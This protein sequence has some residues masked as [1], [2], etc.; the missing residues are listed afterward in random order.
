MS[1]RDTR[2]YVVGLTGGVGSGKSTAAAML[3]AKGVFVI[4]VD[5]I[6]RALSSKG[7]AAVSKIADAFPDVMHNGEIDRT[8]LRERVFANLADRKLLE[9]ILHPMIREQTALELASNAAIDAPYSLLVVPLLFESN[10]YASLIECAVVVDVSVE[11]QVHRVVT[12][13]GVDPAVARNIVAAQ[14][15]REARLSRAQFV[16]NNE[17]DKTTLQ[18]QMDQLH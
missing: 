8:K 7:G 13:R 6:S 1:A 18:R 12:T 2:S 5:D 3:L 17:G 10:A 16:L 11:T 4:D 9:S 14:M 15:T